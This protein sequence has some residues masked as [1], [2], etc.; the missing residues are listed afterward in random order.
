[1]FHVRTAVGHCHFGCQAGSYDQV[2]S[3]S[4]AIPL[5]CGSGRLLRHFHDNGAVAVCISMEPEEHT[6]GFSNKKNTA[7]L[8]DE[9]NSFINDTHFGRIDDIKATDVVSIDDG[10]TKRTLN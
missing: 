9:A 8:T 10:T 4:L 7:V 3:N 2:S 5:P 6:E 1:M